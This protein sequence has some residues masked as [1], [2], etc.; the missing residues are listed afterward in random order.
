MKE[1]KKLFPILLLS[2]FAFYGYS[3]F[4]K[5]PEAILIGI[6][7]L[8]IMLALLVLGI[9]YYLT[10]DTSND[11]FPTT[12]DGFDQTYNGGMNDG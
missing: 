5:I 12:P 6:V 4:F 1:V 10:G 3:Y 2:I 9:T 7:F 8:P 11:F